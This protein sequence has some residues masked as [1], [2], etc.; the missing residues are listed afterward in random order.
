MSYG[1]KNKSM[2]KILILGIK[3]MAGHV[4]FDILS[5]E[6][7]YSVYGVAR[8]VKAT[9]RI[10]NIDVTNTIALKEVIVHHDFDYVINCIGI[11]NKDAEDHPAKAIWFNS[12]FPHYLESITS[13]S[14]TVVMH[15]STDCVFS[16][17]RGNYTENDEKD[18]KGFYAQSKAL[19]EL[20]NNKDLTIRTS[21]IGP[22]LNENGIGL[23][24]WFMTRSPQSSING[25][26]KAHWSGITTIELAGIIKQA[27]KHKLTGLRICASTYKIDKYSLLVLLNTVLR[28]DTIII[29]KD[30]NYQVD[31]SLKSIH[32]DYQFEVQGYKEMICSMK[33]YVESNRDR[34]S[35][36]NSIF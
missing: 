36:Y 12:Y 26:S 14:N 9:N 27:I 16:G 25:F 3:G 28:D 30:S 24:N 22:E 1:I 20:N 35:I 10:F 15:I 21:I 18:G 33:D 34:Y 2:T 4:M 29:E 8:N 13:E 11:L 32:N 17:T 19:G 31:K 5:L 23:F 7:S 6:K